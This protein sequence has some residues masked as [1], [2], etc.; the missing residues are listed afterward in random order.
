M[1][2]TG[3]LSREFLSTHSKVEK[4]A[5][6]GIEEP[7]GNMRWRC[8]SKKIGSMMS[9]ELKGARRRDGFWVR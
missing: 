6:S 5:Y 2:R 1:R 9:F 7:S 3:G 4:L 8:G